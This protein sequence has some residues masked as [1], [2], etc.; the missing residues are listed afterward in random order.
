M[1][2]TN[3]FSGEAHQ[4]RVIFD[5]CEPNV[6]GLISLR[7]LQ[8]LFEEYANSTSISP[9]TFPLPMIYAAKVILYFQNIPIKLMSMYKI[10]S[11]AK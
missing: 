11:K 6:D 1:T 8:Q 4:L 9:D 5:L 2:Q 10:N 3:I 7:R